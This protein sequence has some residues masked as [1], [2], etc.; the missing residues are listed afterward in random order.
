MVPKNINRREET[1]RVRVERIISGYVKHCHPE[2][3]SK[4]YE[5]YQHLNGIYP[6]KKDLRKTR[7]FLMLIQEPARPA[8]IPH[9]RKK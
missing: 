2:V 8:R 1:R 3:Y 4:A 5:F 7:E 9:T 6:D